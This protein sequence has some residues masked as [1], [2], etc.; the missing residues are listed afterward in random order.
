MQPRI[1]IIEDN[2]TN[3]E[4]VAYLITSVGWQTLTATDGEE[5][6][7]L[8]GKE[9]P[10]LILCDINV[11]KLDGFG[12][13]ARLKA[14]PQLHRIPVIAV[15]ALAMVGDRE[16]AFA[17]GFDGYLPKPIVPETFLGT[18][19]SFLPQAKSLPPADAAVAAETAEPELAV[20]SVSSILIVDDQRDNVALCRSLLRPLVRKV[21]AAGSVPEALE[22]IAAEMPDLILSDVLMPGQ[23]GLD[24]LDVLR[25]GR[26]CDGVPFVAISS[27]PEDE[28]KIMMRART[29]WPEATLFR[30]IEAEELRTTIMA[31]LG[32]AEKRS[33]RP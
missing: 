31:F 3:T 25:K 26:I 6:V 14:D 10:D 12:I 17:A 21:R 11:P 18:L 27:V 29:V 4:L 15:T 8:A 2:P 1:L 20:G 5:G 23:G 24:L 28:Y 30:P 32:N 7:A 9:R 13:V 22:A 19:R 16:R 33:S